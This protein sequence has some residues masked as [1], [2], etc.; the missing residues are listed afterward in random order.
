[1][2]SDGF[3]PR[4]EDAP[5]LSGR[6]RFTDDTA[7]PDA[8]VARFLRSP[9]AHAR[10]RTIDTEA[11]RGLEGVVL[12]ATAAELQGDGI[13]TLPAEARLADADG[14]PLREPPRPPLA[15][16][17][18][19][20]VGE[21]L[22]VVVARDEARARDALEAIAVELEPLPAI[23]E[24]RTALEPGAVELH[25]EVP[26]NLAIDWRVGDAAAVE[27]AFA[28]AARIVRVETRFSRIAAHYLEPRAVWAVHEPDHGLTTV[29]VSSQGPHLQKKLLLAATGWAPES[30]RVVSEDVGGGFGPKFPLYPETLLVAWAARRLGRP[31]RWVAERNEHLAAD[32]QA[33]DLDAV[34]ELALDGAGRFL[35]VRVD[36]VAGLGAYLSSLAAT[37][38][39]T[40]LARVI[41]GLYRIPA[42]AVRVRCAYTN[43]PPVDAIRGAGKPETLALL[44][45]AVDRA[46]LE[47]GF[48]PVELRRKNLLRPEDFPWRTPLGYEVEPFD[49]QALLDRALALADRE[50]FPARRA[51]AAARGRLRGLGIACHVHATG[52]MA[53]ELAR[54]ELRPDGTVEAWTG[55]RASG[56]GHATVLARIVAE[57]LGVAPEAVRIRQGDTAALPSG[58]GTGGSS[59]MVVS[60]S[61]LHR[62]AT[63]LA[64]RIRALAAELLEAA[65]ADLRLEGGRVVVAGT[66]RAVALGLVARRAIEAGD[67]LRIEQ[68]AVDPV[69]T[70]PAG[71]TVAELEVDPETGRVEVVRV[72]TA[73]DVGRVLDPVLAAGQVQGGIV[74]GLGEV[75]LERVLF[76]PE[77]GQLLTG[78]LLDYPLPRAAEAP[79]VAIDWVCRPSTR[80]PLGVKGLGELPSNGAPAAI[81][82]ALRDALR[83]L[84]VDAGLDPPVT[85]ERLWRAIRQGRSRRNAEAVSRAGY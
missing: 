74:A 4:L 75:L 43:T 37:V 21:A 42:I 45:A 84:G 34:L 59:S 76:D 2:G 65:P 41:S 5:L 46:A 62:G 32:A 44:E 22:A 73:L 17:R 56:Q 49:G 83:P 67:P 70:W 8:L 40:G 51:E 27:A 85:P 81:L 69:Q 80:N 55:T 68:P 39:T 20:H 57:P 36:A 47:G 64:E 48:D 15:R 58:P 33:R 31:V 13:G 25:P 12:V 66:D 7:P 38:P 14:R 3:G 28:R 50:R 52:A 82:A 19:R 72:A 26:G 60:G 18:V 6:G 79:P 9:R 30:L 71:V 24:P 10:I 63:A 77:S 53:G 11:A 54:L 61:S 16:D 23:V 78:S 1:M 35:A 29:T